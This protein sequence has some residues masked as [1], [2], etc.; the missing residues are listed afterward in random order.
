M[1]LV[2]YISRRPNQKARKVS[3]Y[4]EVFI[5]AKLKLISA[6][7]DSLNLKP[8]SAI[9]KLIQ[10]HDPAYQITPIFEAT[11]N[12][13]TLI[14]THATRVHE[15]D[16]HLSL[17]LRNQISNTS[18]NFNNLKYEYTSSQITINTS[19]AKQ[20]TTDFEHSFQNRKELSLAPRETQSI[21]PYFPPIRRHSTNISKSPPR[22]R[23]SA[24]CLILEIICPILIQIILF[25][26]KIP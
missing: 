5:A 17:P 15:H 12:A 13:T 9:H 23:I 16:S 25:N 3:A 18:G 10:A 8:G 19:L 1:G 22:N 7:V 24:F 6:S 20:N 21:K 14:S 11:H 26:S 4:D 2:D